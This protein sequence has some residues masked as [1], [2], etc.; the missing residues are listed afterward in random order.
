MNKIWVALVLCVAPMSALAQEGDEDE[1]P[2]IDWAWEDGYTRPDGVSVDGFYRVRERAGFEWQAPGVSENGEWTEPGWRAKDPAPAG[3]AWVPGHR[4]ED[5][6]WVDGTWRPVERDGYDWVDARAD[7][8]VWVI[9][10]WHPR[11]VR[12]GHVWAPG[13]WTRDG[14]WVDGHWREPARDGQ[15]WVPGLFRFGAWHHGYWR[16]RAN[17]PGEL[18]VGGYHG[19]KGWVDGHWR[20]GNNPGH[21]WVSGHWRA[22]AFVVGAWIAG[23]NHPARRFGRPEPVRT[24]LKARAKAH[25]VFKAVTHP[26]KTVHKVVTHPGKDIKVKV[27]V[28]K[29]GKPGKRG[30]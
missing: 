1:A 5:G 29:P 3:M 21:R 8:A 9:G 20:K 18:W 4:A 27:K 28:V 16:P 7:N 19:P 6:Y 22:G 24:M 10:H 17:R 26:G 30:K 15:L 12:A 25:R 13:H 2:D 23:A 14:D 11:V